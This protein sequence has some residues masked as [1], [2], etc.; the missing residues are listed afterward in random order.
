M[1]VHRGG[2]CPPYPAKRHL[3]WEL[4]DADGKSLE[5]DRR[6]CDENDDW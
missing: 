4:D 5:T 3:G 6:I 2:A 1:A